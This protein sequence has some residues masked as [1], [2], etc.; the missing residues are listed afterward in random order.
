MLIPIKHENMSARRWPVI[1]LGLIAINVLCLLF[2]SATVD[3][4]AKKQAGTTRA[5][6]LMLAAAHPQ[7]TVT[8]ETQKLIDS[9][10]E[11]NPKIWTELSNESRPVADGWD[12][13]MRMMVEQEQWQA[14]MARLE[15]EYARL[16]AE[17]MTETYAFIP[18]RRTA[19]SYL[20]ANFLHGGWMHLIGNMW[21]LWL[22]GFV[23]EDVWGRP[24]YLTFYLVAGAASMQFYAWTAPHSLTPTLG[25]SGA[26]AGLM[27]AFLVRFPTMKIEMGWLWFTWRFRFTKFK[28]PAWS[29]L[30]LWLAMEA[31]S[32][33]LFGHSDGVA[34]WTHVGGF[35][36]GAI[37]ALVIRASGVEKSL[38]KKV[39]EELELAH[40]PEIES[41]TELLHA[42]KMVE[43]QSVLEAYVKAKPDSADGWTLLSQVYRRKND[44]AAWME[45]CLRMCALHVKA[46]AL[47]M[48]E[49]DVADYVT[50]GGQQLPADLWLALGAAYERGREFDRAVHEYSGVAQAYPK[51]RESVLALVAAAKLCLKELHQAKQALDFYRQ[52]EASTA[53]HADVD[54]AIQAGIREASAAA[55]SF[56]AQSAAPKV[57]AAAAGA[58]GWNDVGYGATFSSGDDL[59]PQSAYGAWT[60]DASAESGPDIVLAWEQVSAAAPV[61]QAEPVVEAKPVPPK[62]PAAWGEFEA[63]PVWGHGAKGDTIHKPDFNADQ[64]KDRR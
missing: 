49:R 19:I 7:L 57:A 39:T 10:K 55:P 12:A 59:A 35:L 8:P 27:G 60:P 53:P 23:L 1:T 34:H 4:E 37:F 22:A 51:Q 48:A 54:E 45:A 14:E 28:A 50:A 29:L 42:G 18:G 2:T 58:R 17:N 24:L 41:A 52:A 20:T 44:M 13:Q 11:D 31:F 62:K 56:G 3:R 43:A 46:D 64:V 36:F 40:D 5:H 21:F 9:F 30:L 63:P 15:E 26:V 33:F 16:K 47:E 38:T 61:A 25:A 32:G 6:I